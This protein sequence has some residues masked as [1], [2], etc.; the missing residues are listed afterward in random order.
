MVVGHIHDPGS[1]FLVMPMIL[2]HH[3]AHMWGWCA[4]SLLEAKWR[5]LERWQHY[6]GGPDH[7]H[8]RKGM[9]EGLVLIEETRQGMGVFQHQDAFCQSVSDGNFHPNLPWRQLRKRAFIP[10]NSEGNKLF[11]LP[12]E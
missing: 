1:W 3:D 4:M 6:K 11:F 10:Q 8:G 7:G 9:P 2:V 12:L 5:A